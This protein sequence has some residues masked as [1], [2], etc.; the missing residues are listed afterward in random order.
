MKNGR[1]TK[2]KKYYN[3]IMAS[4]MDLAN[5]PQLGKLYDTLSLDVYGYKC[6][7]HIIFFREISKNEIEVQ[8]ILHS[9]MD[10]KNKL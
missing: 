9:M 5:N 8:R 6:G 3:L 1:K 10:L 2:L 7:Q 4:C